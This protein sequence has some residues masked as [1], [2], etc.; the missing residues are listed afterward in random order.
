M[1]DV[2][3]I[4]Q[5]S[6]KLIWIGTSNGLFRYDGTNTIYLRHKPGDTSSIPNN[7]IICITEDKNKNIWIGTLGGVASVNPY[8][9]KCKVYRSELNN[10][11]ENFDNKII[12][13]PNGKIWTG[14][15]QGLF[16][17]DEKANRFR[18]VWK[19]PLPDKPV[20]GYVTC[21]D[22][23]KPDTLVLGTFDDLVLLNT[24]NYGYR[25][26]R[27]FDKNVLVTRLHVDAGHRLWIGT[28]GE[29]CIIGNRFLSSF[30]SY[31]WEKDLRSNVDNVVTAI[32][33]SNSLN[34]KTI[35]V[36]SEQIIFKFPIAFTDS[37]VD[38]SK[39]Q[40]YPNSQH[41]NN[42]PG[43]VSCML[44][45]DENNIWTGG[46]VVSKFSAE[47]YRFQ[48][49]PRELK[50]S[51]Q[52][53][54]SIIINKKEY[55]VLSMWHGTQ[56]ML[57]IDQQTGSIK[58]IDSIGKNDQYG[59][60]GSGVA[61]DKFDRIWLAS[62][63][64]TY[65]LDSRFHF[66]YDLTKPLNPA[67]SPTARK[68]NEILIHHDTVWLADYKKGIDIFDLNGHK[69]K[70]YIDG[71]N[72]GLKDGLFEKFFVDSH[73]N[74]WICGNSYLH[75]YLPATGRFKKYDLSVE[76]STYSPHDIAE[77][78][79]GR[80]MIAAETGLICF[81]P[82][83]ERFYNISTPL[84]KMEENVSSVC[85]DIN[86]DVWYLTSN[87]LVY[88]KVRSKKFTLFGEEDGL[89]IYNLNLIRSFDGIRFFLANGKKLLQFT[90][91]NWEQKT[92]RPQL[93]MHTIQ[94]ND[95]TVLSENPLAELKLHHDQNKIYFE[96]DAIGYNKPEQNQYAY[97]LNGID[98]GWTISNRNFVSY[99]HLSPGNY[100]FHV[101]GENYTGDWSKEYIV[102]ISIQPPF[103]LTWWFLGLLLFAI[104]I[105]FFFIVRYI[106]QRN[107]R[108]KILRL[109]K[110]QAV[111]KERNRIAR[112]MHDDLGSGLTKIAIL[113]EVAKTQLQQK[114]EA[115]IQLEK[116]SFSSRELVDNLQD[117]IWVLN[118]KND[119]LESLAVYIR[120]YTLK[121]F[122]ASQLTVH[123]DYPQQMPAHKL[124][125]EQRRNIFLVIKE[126]LNNIAKHAEAESIT[127]S[128]LANKDAL[129]VSIK[130]DG[131]GFDRLSVRPFANGLSNMKNRVEQIGGV[132][133]IISCPRQGSET[134]LS[135][136]F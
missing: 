59:S 135:I 129:E 117:I 7:T 70:H 25:R 85:A 99:S 64:G 53:I 35:W 76:H 42:D 72:S 21:L 71:D 101:K 88:Y 19:Q 84:L 61:K 114:D 68:T 106:S 111:E 124:S 128:L 82:V 6:R 97:R 126:T 93:L 132:Y 96:F 122:D 108:E 103:W 14:N 62:L 94:V 90:P 33:E 38:I 30:Q 2:R 105:L 15:S 78:P 13:G 127:V 65:I 22:F 11:D 102:Q 40:R 109:E 46:T 104:L 57:I 67:D 31:K 17:L 49:F 28:W 134:K 43:I 58:T 95:S 54:Q 75:K 29:G 66:I 119:S 23:W 73:D 87:H 48:L 121:F 39:V 74:L 77:L 63:A 41:Q 120:E 47:K 12:I 4:F 18:N 3:S 112:D 100:E 80:L 69:L 136:P 32:S 107:L 20:S 5:D 55:L 52:N 16:L 34:D 91:A 125:E 115:A 8:N 27:P 45:D 92:D 50:G 26:I 98:K 123:F 9:F 118:P 83:T 51:V 44:A 10:L 113:S 56:A 37:N 36:R 131:R 81:D 86:G 116:I 130:D 133:E 79:D 60:N 110:E 1:K 89:D 24:N